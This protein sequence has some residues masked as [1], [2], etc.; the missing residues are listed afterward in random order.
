[1]M[2]AETVHSQ[3]ERQ[4]HHFSGEAEAQTHLCNSAAVNENCSHLVFSVLARLLAVF[5]GASIHLVLA[6]SIAKWTL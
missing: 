3:T 5:V 2:Q 6:L 1:M 4:I